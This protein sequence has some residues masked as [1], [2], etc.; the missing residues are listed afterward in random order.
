MARNPFSVPFLMIGGGAFA[1]VA[2]IAL[3]ATTPSSP[4]EQKAEAPPA[5]IGLSDYGAP[6]ANDPALDASADAPLTPLYR[7]LGIQKTTRQVNPSEVSDKLRRYEVRCVIAT[8]PHPTKSGIGYWYD[9]SLDAIE[10]AVEQAGYVPDRAWTPP[11]WRRPPAKDAKIYAVDGGEPDERPGMLLFRQS[12]NKGLCIVWLVG[13]T[14]TSGI[15]KDA[16]KAIVSLCGKYHLGPT[17]E[18]RI[19]GPFFSGSQPSLIAAL[20]DILAARNPTEAAGP[21]SIIIRNGGAAAIRPDDFD[22]LSRENPL[23]LSVVEGAESL[24]GSSLG[25]SPIVAA[26]A[27]RIIAPRIDYQTTVIPYKTMRQQLLRYLDSPSFPHEGNRPEKVAVL[28]E[29]DTGYG[30]GSREDADKPNKDAGQIDIPFPIHISALQGA[31]NRELAD[32]LTQLGLPRPSGPPI[33]QEEGEREGD[34]RTLVRSQSPY[35]AGAINDL[36]MKNTLTSLRHE[37]VKYVE[38]VAT[39][40]RD[41]ILLATLVRDRCPD[42]QLFTINGDFMLAHP[43]FNAPLRGTIIG[44]CYP[45]DAQALSKPPYADIQATRGLRLLFGNQN[46]Q[47]SYNALLSLL[48]RGEGKLAKQM[49]GYGP[50]K[51]DKNWEYPSVWISVIGQ[52]GVFTPVYKIPVDSDLKREFDKQKVVKRSSVKEDG[53]SPSAPPFSVPA[54]FSTISLCGL[55]L[56]SAWLCV[57]LFRGLAAFTNLDD[58]QA[59]LRPVPFAEEIKRLCLAG[60]CLCPACLYAWLFA[61]AL[62][63]NSPDA[64]G[65]RVNKLVLAITACMWLV[66]CY[67]FMRRSAA[68]AWRAWPQAAADPTPADFVTRDLENRFYALLLIAFLA[69]TGMI[70]YNRYRFEDDENLFL[71]FDRV[72]HFTAGLS[73]LTP[74]ALLI[75]CL[76][77]YCY[78][79]FRKTHHLQHYVVENPF[80]FVPPIQAFYKLGRLGSHIERTLQSPFFWGT[81]APGGGRDVF[82]VGRYLALALPVLILAVVFGHLYAYWIPS[83]EGRLFDLL[84]F[85]GLFVCAVLTVYVSYHFYA[86]WGRLRELLKEV[87]KLPL[88][89]AFNRLPETVRAIV[90]GALY[91]NRPGHSALDLARQQLQL[92]AVTLPGDALRNDLPDQDKNK[93]DRLE[94]VL[95]VSETLPPT[96]DGLSGK[97]IDEMSRQLRETFSVVLPLL[98]VFWQ[99]RSLSDKYTLPAAGPR[100]ADAKPDSDKPPQAGPSPVRVWLDCAED[101]VA[102]EITRYLSQ[103]FAQLR[104]I[105]NAVVLGAFLMLLTITVYPFHPQSLLLLYLVILLGAVVVLAVWVLVAINRDEVMSH[106][107]GNAPNQFTPDLAFFKQIGQYVVPILGL[108]AVQFPAVGTFIRSMLEPLLRMMH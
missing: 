86:V 39:D 33:P 42:A 36:I 103:F 83:I 60:V 6:G 26:A 101:F 1:F 21:F 45:M 97:N 64:Q 84:L 29:S 100:A 3:R 58:E 66:L 78:F 76:S 19:L 81:R 51:A 92:L 93:V 23:C 108:L 48:D 30:A 41:K 98:A 95:K 99:H 20:R 34:A 7:F 63:P 77:A 87:A 59:T 80:Q 104:N 96:S 8:V 49:L 35:T 46:F 14:P 54:R 56:A 25:Q 70:I 89:K 91:A 4:A 37:R 44:S 106:I 62:M 38:L 12:D 27:C 85:V 40:P 11:A 75:L 5:K 73:P 79:L 67:Q 9:L 18:L 68:A 90:D 47:G 72:T 102:V 2:A 94:R 28:R 69:V 16:L 31:H 43:D 74:A 82:R 105:L 57:F 17:G 32:Q 61:L 52:N 24:L 88:P 50:S 55:C 71:Y 53:Q 22:D 10:R 15:E 107:S 65:D 13:E